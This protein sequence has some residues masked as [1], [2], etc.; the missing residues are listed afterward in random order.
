MPKI[1][2][3]PDTTSLHEAHTS[4]QQ[5]WQLSWPIM[6]SNITVPLVGVVDVAMMGRL[7]DPVFIG[8]VGLGMMVFILCILVG[9]CAQYHRSVAQMYGAGQMLPLLIF[10]AWCQR[11]TWSWGDLLPSPLSLVQQSQYFQQTC[12]RGID[13]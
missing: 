7:N 5:I 1:K 4:W 13:D 8:G 2:P 12:G 11:R 3:K 6:L 10:Y 9:F